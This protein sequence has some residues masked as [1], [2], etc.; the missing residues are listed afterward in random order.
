MSALTTPVPT[1]DSHMYRTMRRQPDD[2]R[3]L[4]ADGW[5]AA[6]EAADLLAGVERV[7]L[8]GIGT[9]YHAALVGAWLLGAAAVDARAVSSFDFAHY[10][11]QYRVGSR[12]A[13]IVMAHTGVKR[14]SAASLQIAAAARATILSVGSQ[15]AEHPGSQLILRTVEREQSAAYTASHLAAMTVLAQVAAELGGRNEAAAV[16][17]FREG[18]AALPDQVAGV[19]DREAEIVPVAQDAVS[20]R[21]YATGAG[22]NEVSALELVIKAREAAYATIDALPLEQF[23]HGPMVAVNADDQAVVIHTPGAAAT[24][25]A[26]VAAVLNGIGARL[27]LVGEPVASLPD[28]TTFALPAIPEILS[29]LLTVVPMQMFAYQ[30]ATLKGLNP[31]TFRRDNPRYAEAFGLL[32]L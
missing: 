32:K 1:T 19:L 3:R 2:L 22:P 24:R 12:D 4:L 7:F 8:A 10:P 30:M 11:E 31:D 26:E 29:P 14:F 25:V 13:V 15:T 28:V 6:G 27:W 20:R 17:G 5:G 23:L 9:S 21:I 16:A 18:L